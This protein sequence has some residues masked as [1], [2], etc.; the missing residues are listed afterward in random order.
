MECLS[1]FDIIKHIVD[2]VKYFDAPLAGRIELF[3]LTGGRTNFWC[4][5][6][7][8]YGRNDRTIEGRE[9]GPI[10]QASY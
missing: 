4:D 1:I 8:V 10:R 7:R 6:A 9:M 2:Y 3:R 5:F